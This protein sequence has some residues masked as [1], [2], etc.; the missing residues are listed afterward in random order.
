MTMAEEAA[1]NSIESKTAGTFRSL[2]QRN[3][4]LFFGGQLIS[5]VGNWLTLIA[6][7]LL[8]LDLT[9]SGIALG[10]LAACQFGPVLVLGAWAGVIADRSDKRKLLFTVQIVA[11]AQSFALAI[12]AFMDH[13]SVVA[14]YVIA[15][16][17]GI[18][19]AFDNPARRAFVTEM[20]PES[21]VQ[22]AVSLNSA[23]MTGARIFGPALAGLLIQTAGYGWTFV[24]DAVSYLAVLFGYGMMRV[25]ELRVP[26]V[27]ARAKGQIREGFRYARRTPDLWVPLMMMTLVG[28]LSFNFP[29]F[30]PLLVER[31]LHSTETVYTLLYSI[32]SVGSLVGALVAARKTTIT[33]RDITVAS[34]GFGVSML[35]L[36]LSPNIPFAS[37]A[38]VL[39]G[40]TS[41]SFMTGSTTIVQLRSSAEMR[42]R[43]LA[44]QSIVFLGSTPIGG[45]IIGW[46]C[47]R[48]GARWGVFTG[49]A[50]ALVA[51]VYGWTKHRAFGRAVAPA[52]EA[53]AAA[54]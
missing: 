9:D 11:M 36:G 53:V 21:D 19:T 46:I 10:L 43:V 39:L 18:A 8:V 51:G 52:G 4:R 33:I 17:G 54:H 12:V 23:V 37:A 7:G 27:V 45:P 1:P 38:G 34:L 40:V 3:F 35:L 13:P 44:L 15:V 42:G 47:E 26:K 31:S 41:I 48:F 16:F 20:V 6:M 50:A 32:I 25:S 28:T 30:M 49:G 24:A 14:L 5:Q 2:R 29:T 22:N